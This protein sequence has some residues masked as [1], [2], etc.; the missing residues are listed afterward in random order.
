[1]LS[2]ELR[3]NYH[4]ERFRE[5]LS[6]FFS[7]LPELEESATNAP[8]LNFP[9]P[10]EHQIVQWEE[11][12]GEQRWAVSTLD[13]VERYRIAVDSFSAPREFKRQLYHLLSELLDISP[14]WGALTG[15]RPTMV[16]SQ[17]QEQRPREKIAAALIEDYGLSPEK[18]AL[19][20]EVE[21]HEQAILKRLPV[22]Q[23]LVYIGI[24]FCPS[25]CS[26]CSFIAHDARRYRKQLRAYLEAV[27]SDMRAFY[28]GHE[29]EIS[30]LYFGGG[31]PSSPELE[32]LAYLLEEAWAILPL[33]KDCEITFEAGRPDS[34]S[35]EKVALFCQYGIERLCL[36]PQTTCQ[37]TLETIGRGHTVSDFYRAEKWLRESGSVILNMDL[38]AGLPGEDGARFLQSLEEVLALDPEN[39][40]LHAL[41][42]KRTARLRLEGDIQ[43]LKNEARAI[44]L[45]EA[46]QE[47]QRRLRAAGYEP[48]YLYRQK[49]LVAGLENTGFAKPGTE[50]RY[51]VG[52]MSDRR[53]VVG[54][55]AGASS[56]AVFGTRLE[57]YINVKDI[58]LYIERWPEE[59]AK[60]LQLFAGER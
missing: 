53:S 29:R 24:P 28:E 54:F 39:I 8:L 22:S 59:C 37:A 13:G 49:N 34:L 1:M 7:R 50:S 18:A 44:D 36:N 60:R 15:V 33:A 52:M 23:D 27:A 43:Q 55:G 31:T 21:A 6:L 17:L 46:M 2:V 57:R 20:L 9:M 19:A 10:E 41:A 42:L 5:V 4:I 40:T 51:N 48:Y 47:A 14:L 12:E 26:Y 30:A 25:R 32:D 58:G 3:Q 11:G 38:I 16:V 35:P 56:K 45:Q